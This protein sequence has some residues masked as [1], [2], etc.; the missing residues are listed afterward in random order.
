[1]LTSQLE[2]QHDRRDYRPH[3]FMTTLLFRDDCLKYRIVK[4]DI[5]TH[6]KQFQRSK[7]LTIGT[8]TPHV[9]SFSARS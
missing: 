4:F 5:D 8:E 1:M 6:Q 3:L 9:R 2:H 7:A